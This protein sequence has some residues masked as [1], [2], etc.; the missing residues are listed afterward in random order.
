MRNAVFRTWD[1]FSIKNCKEVFLEGYITIKE[2]GIFDSFPTAWANCVQCFSLSD[3]I[4]I[5][6]ELH[7]FFFFLAKKNC[8]SAKT[9]TKRPCREGTDEK[10]IIG[11]CSSNIFRVLYFPAYGEQLKKE[12]GQFYLCWLEHDLHRAIEEGEW[13]LGE[14][15]G[16]YEHGREPGSPSASRTP[17]QTWSTSWAAGTRWNNSKTHSSKLMNYLLICGIKQ[18]LLLWYMA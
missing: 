11:H 1:C 2:H 15:I 18:R 10:E 6:Q 7:F 5:S 17:A 4:V 9:K 3:F 14:A 16:A 12:G 8:I 13:D